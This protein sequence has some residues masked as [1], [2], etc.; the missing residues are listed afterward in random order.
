[1]NHTLIKLTRMI[2]FTIFT[3]MMIPTSAHATIIGTDEAKKIRTEGTAM[4]KKHTKRQQNSKITSGRVLN[5]IVATLSKN[6][7]CGYLLNTPSVFIS[8]GYSTVTPCKRRLNMTRVTIPAMSSVVTLS[9]S[10]IVKSK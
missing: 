4:H 2:I 7:P 8:I 5:D 9:M 1:M 6:K 3:F 10:P